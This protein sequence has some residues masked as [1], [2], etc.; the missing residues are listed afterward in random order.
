MLF[1]SV[2][3]WYNNWESNW[4]AQSQ[5]ADKGEILVHSPTQWVLRRKQV[6]NTQRFQVWSVRWIR[7]F[8]TIKSGFLLWKKPSLHSCLSSASL[9][10]C[11]HQY[12]LGPDKYSNWNS[13]FTEK[14]DQIH[15]QKVDLISQRTKP[16]DGS[17][18]LCVVSSYTCLVYLIFVFVCV[19]GDYMKHYGNSYW[20][21]EVNTSYLQCIILRKCLMKGFSTNNPGYK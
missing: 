11:I 16:D 13:H 14:K 17:T 21:L 12:L 2:A 1:A 19:R 6:N 8:R 3:V 5:E 18:F 4:W 7:I 20:K 10:R 9:L 15:K